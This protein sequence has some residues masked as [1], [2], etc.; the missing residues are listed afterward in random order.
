MKEMLGMYKQLNEKQKAMLFN[1]EQRKCLDSLVF[2]EKLFSDKKFYNSVES[3][4]GEETYKELKAK[5]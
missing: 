1:G 2:F 5:A 4:I 3:A